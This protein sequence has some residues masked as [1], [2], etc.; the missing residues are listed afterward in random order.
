MIIVKILGGLGNQMFQYAYARN[1][2]EL[3]HEVKLDASWF[4]N[5][6]LHGG[7][8]L[9][10]Y[11]ISIKFAT[12]KDLLNFGIHSLRSKLLRKIGLSNNKLYKEK[13]E[14]SNY[15]LPVIGSEMYIDGNF[16]K[17]G[18]FEEITNI[19]VREFTLKNALS[20]RSN[21]I[22]NDIK[23]RKFTCSVHVRR[24]DYLR[25][26]NKHHGL[27]SMSYYRKA[28]DYMKSNIS[29]QV[30]FFIF[31]DDIQWA[32]NNFADDNIIFVSGEEND[33]PYEEMYLMSLCQG[34]IL[35]NSTFSWWAAVLNENVDKKVVSPKEWLCN[36]KY[37]LSRPEWI[38]I[39]DKGVYF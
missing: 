8:Q 31:S 22:K 16:L 17:I 29:I 36:S 27:C 5:Y 24:G 28:M 20:K 19:L 7:L 35:A 13:L 23:S 15:F 10:N 3:G 11:D 6:N 30:N 21:F 1:L 14:V 34:N 32:K 18:Y 37:N 12:E 26:N 2:V 4:K 39:S 38:E 9:N 33:K 25:A